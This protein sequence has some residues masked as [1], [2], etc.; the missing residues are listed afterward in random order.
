[1][2]ELQ[3]RAAIERVL[4]Q[5]CRFIDAVELDALA[6]LFTEDCFVE[7]GPDANFSS[8]GRAQLRRDLER[9]WR[10]R[11][12]A[13]Q[14][15]NIEIDFVGPDEAHVLSSVIAWHERPDEQQ[16]EVVALYG[17]YDDTL[18]R[19]GDG[20]RIARR[21]LMNSGGDRVFDSTIYP[22]ER[23]PKPPGWQWPPASR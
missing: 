4:I 13:H 1:L 7:Y 22:A 11:R 17:R 3:E 9:M 21:K 6:A 16:R 14:M 20:W 8:R 5:Y 12:T 10:Y 15:S 19:T 18:V 2:R 23:Q